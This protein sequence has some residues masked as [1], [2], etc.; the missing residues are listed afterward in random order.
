[1]LPVVALLGEL[2]CCM[3]SG[4]ASIVGD[5]VGEFSLWAQPKKKGRHLFWRDENMPRLGKS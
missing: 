3:L 5:R 2:G 4:M 1:M